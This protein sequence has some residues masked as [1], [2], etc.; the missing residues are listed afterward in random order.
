MLAYADYKTTPAS[1]ALLTG[2]RSLKREERI[3]PVAWMDKHFKLVGQSSGISG[4]W[5]TFPYQR[6]MLHAFDD[7]RI[8]FIGVQKSTR[9]GYTKM[10]TGGALRCTAYKKRNVT[11]YQPSD[12]DAKDFEKDE[13]APAIDASEYIRSKLKAE[14]ADK[15]GSSNTTLRK[16]FSP[17]ILHLLGAESPK[18]YRRVTA[19]VTIGD[20]IDEFPDNVGKSKDKKQGSPIRLMARALTDSP[21]KKQIVGSSPTTEDGSLINRQM[22]RLKGRTFDRHF[23]CPDCN[24]WQP[25]VWGGADSAS[26]GITFVDNDP[27]TARYACRACASLWEYQ[28]LL[29]M[30]QTGEWRSDHL[31]IRDVDGEFFKISDVNFKKPVAP[32]RRMGFFMNSMYSP[33]VSWEELVETFL[34]AVSASLAGD[35]TE[36][37]T[38]TNHLLGQTWKEVIH[39]VIDPSEFELKHCVSYRAQVPAEVLFMTCGIDVQKDHVHIDIVGWGE[40]QVNFGIRYTRHFGSLD[41]P[42]F[43]DEME[44]IITQDF[45]CENGETM[46]VFLTC[47]DSGHRAKEVYR[48]CRKNA[49]KYIP[50]KGMPA[51]KGQQEIDFPQKRNKERTFL[52][53]VGGDAINN[54]LRDR[55]AMEVEGDYVPTGFS[56]WPKGEGYDPRYFKE[57]L[58]DQKIKK[59]AVWS[60]EPP[61]GIAND[62]ADARKYAYA[63]MKIAVFEMGKDLTPKVIDPNAKSANQDV[64]DRIRKLSKKIN[65]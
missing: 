55:Y 56:F 45:R 37:I 49:I 43:W 5:E 12:G 7:D 21:F 14:Y 3:D 53:W 18:N 25:L 50:V 60:W 4:D 44:R 22:K 11:F 35:N 26:S 33:F 15:K 19:H 30:D 16:E 23:C 27:S 51:K 8:R 59:G 6:A 65:G 29:T 34:T 39:D 42:F 40:R 13:V 41:D 10:I 24:E 63:A 57:L 52:T 61:V 2:L 28:Q 64:Y 32:P 36:L 62:A 54:I 1:D 58:S 38:F 9:M 20:E 48:F 31:K 46:N 17:A 47:I